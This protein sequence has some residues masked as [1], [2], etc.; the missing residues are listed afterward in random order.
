ME[1][2]AGSLKN[3]LLKYIKKSKFCPH[4]YYTIKKEWSYCA[5][6]G[7]PLKQKGTDKK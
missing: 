6:C 7:I 4:C 1:K 2:E 5:H 3:K